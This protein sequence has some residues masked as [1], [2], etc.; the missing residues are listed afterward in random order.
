MLEGRIQTTMEVWPIER[1]LSKFKEKRSNS[2]C[3]FIAPSIFSD[4]YSQIEWLKDKKSLFIYPKKIKNFIRYL[5]ENQKL[6][7]F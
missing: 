1:H 3:Y 6:Y 2:I 4:S 5:E 7:T